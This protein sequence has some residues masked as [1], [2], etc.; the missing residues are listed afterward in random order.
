MSVFSPYQ[1]RDKP[2][3]AKNAEKIASEALANSTMNQEKTHAR[4]A[5]RHT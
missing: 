5:N 3:I 2:S 1:S 4:D